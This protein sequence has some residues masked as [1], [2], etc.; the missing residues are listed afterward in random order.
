MSTY[1]S[2]N[3]VYSSLRLSLQAIGRKYGL[4]MS[5]SVVTLP[6]EIWLIIFEMIMEPTLAPYKYCTSDTFPRYRVDH[7]PYA[8]AEYQQA[9]VEQQSPRHT[10]AWLRLTLVCSTW[11][12]I[13]GPCPHM[14][15]TGDIYGWRRGIRS[16]AWCYSISQH[17]AP[18]KGLTQ[19]PHAIDQLTSLYIKNT[20]HHNGSLHPLEPLVR[21]LPKLP[22][23]QYLRIDSERETSGTWA[24]LEDRFPNLVSL[25]VLNCSVPLR[26][27]TFPR[28]EILSIRDDVAFKSDLPLNLKLPRLK[29]CAIKVPKLDTHQFFVDHGHQ[30]E[31]LTI[32]M[33]RQRFQDDS[34][35]WELFPGL[36]TLE[37][38]YLMLKRLSPPPVDH[39]L[40]LLVLLDLANNWPKDIIRSIIAKFPNLQRV[41]VAESALTPPKHRSL[42]HLVTEHGITFTTHALL[43]PPKSSKRGIR[44]AER[45]PIVEA[46]LNLVDLTKSL[47]FSSFSLL[48]IDY[49]RFGSRIKGIWKRTSLPCPRFRSGFLD[50]RVA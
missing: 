3:R 32:V 33:N 37:T 42:R 1:V 12:N 24:I 38:G 50:P 26:R 19:F 43:L 30:L 49:Q 17:L 23:L 13:I 28:L 8:D 27:V 29:H 4:V 40:R 45:Y 22:A 16:V 6:P 31:S 9:T 21:Y 48:R 14:Q 34:G 10:D 11:A 15:A 25:S 39:P 20:H 41:C 35:F 2:Q 47:L 18:L 44:W 5:P 46:S 7:A 36:L